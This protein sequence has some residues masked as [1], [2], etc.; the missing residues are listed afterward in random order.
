MAR[1]KN[2]EATNALFSG[3]TSDIIK[4]ETKKT[5][6]DI[7]ETT[8]VHANAKTEKRMGRP[9]VTT[10]KKTKNILLQLKPSLHQIIKDEAD[11]V[12]MSVNAF[13]TLLITDGLEK[14]RLL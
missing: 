1:N 5:E 7:Q 10:E 3:L 8:D 11:R 4:K 13:I 6:T 14:R 12:S 9:P 2:E